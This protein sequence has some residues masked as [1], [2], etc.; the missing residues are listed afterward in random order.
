MKKSVSSLV[1]F[2]GL[3]IST[4]AFAQTLSQPVDMPMETRYIN[5]DGTE[6]TGY[7][8]R[9]SALVYQSTRNPFCAGGAFFATFDATNTLQPHVFVE[10]FDF[11]PGPWGA[12]TANGLT[13][14]SIPIQNFGTTTRSYVLSVR[15]YNEAVDYVTPGQLIPAGAA[16]TGFNVNITQPANTFTNWVIALNPAT[17]VF[18]D[19]NG[20]LVV[21]LSTDGALANALPVTVPLRFV[22][23]GRDGAALPGTSDALSGFDFDGDDDVQVTADVNTTDVFADDPAPAGCGALRV[24]FAMKGDV[25]PTPPSFTQINPV[26]INDG[27]TTVSTPIAANQVKWYRFTVGPSGAQDNV[28][29][30]VDIDGSTVTDTVIALYDDN[31]N[32][33]GNPDDNDGSGNLSQLTYGIGRRAAFGDGRQYDGRDAQLT[34]GDYFIGVAA[35]PAT[36]SGAYIAAS[37][38]TETG[39]IQVRI[40]SN[41]NGT[42]AAAAVAPVPNFDLGPINVLTAVGEAAPAMQ[43]GDVIWFKFDVCEGTDANNYIDVDFSRCNEG[44]DPFVSIFDSNGNIVIEDDDSGNLELPQ[45]SFGG[46]VARPAYSGAPADPAFNGESGP[47]AAGTTV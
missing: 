28:Q 46:T 43:A 14:F 19:N 17:F 39:N 8:E 30:C 32:L 10:D 34:P 44:T 27:S 42:P 12:T 6:A 4:V 9:A 15:L 13:E 45:L 29:T 18:P 7:Q 21:W 23:A 22:V 24:G 26:P 5:L 40:N 47:L 20:K 38:S 3:A 16:V 11:N 33:V 31:G 41:S 25:L 35:A 2:A 37:T 1:G 36:F